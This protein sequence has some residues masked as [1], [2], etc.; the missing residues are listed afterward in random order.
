MPL[1]LG[2]ESSCDE[3]AL[4][5]V[6]DSRLL[7]ESLSSQAD[8]HALF[9]GVVP[10]IASREHY[11]LLDGLLNDLLGR[12]G[13]TLN[14][15]E[16]VSVARGP[17]LL[18][19]LLV[20]LG[21][22]KGLAMGLNVPLVGVNHLQAHLLAPGLT[23]QLIFPAVGLLVSGGHTHLYYIKSEL[24]FEL[25]GRTLDDAAGEVFDKVAKMLNLPYPGGKFID[26]FAQAAEPDQRLF[27]RPYLDNQNLD[28]SFSGLKTAVSLYLADQAGLVFRQMPTAGEVSGSPD[29]ALAR[30]CA[31]FNYSVA[32]T[33]KIKTA[34]ALARAPEAKSLILA[35]GV[36][37]NQGIRAS[38]ARLARQF[39]LTLLLP[40][41]ELCTDNAAMIAFAGER[42]AKAGYR[43]GLDLEAVPRG[44]SVPWDYER[45]APA[46]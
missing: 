23:Q 10:E 32:E 14:E 35:G 13:R 3:T 12:T 33:L 1:C 2:I 39:G 38:I 30:L 5:L 26:M 8:I 17:G 21:F 16:V 19:S 43:H 15:V 28:F 41:P 25:W 9:G 29:P 27:P 18:G 20:G 4:A 45:T 24:E 46:A 42:L 34:R 44:R 7:G 31:S 37:A 36:A 6:E 11:R 22:A 40:S